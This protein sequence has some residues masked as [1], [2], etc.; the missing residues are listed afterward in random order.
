MKLFFHPDPTADYTLSEE[1]SLHAVK[2]LRLKE[3]DTL[4]I[5]DGKG[6]LFEAQITNAHPKKCSFAILNSKKETKNRTYNLHLAIAPTKSIDRMEWL[7]EKAVEVGI[8][9]ISFLQ[10]DRSERKNINLERVE[11][12][13]ISG[14]KQSMNL[15]LPIVNEMIPFHKFISTSRNEKCFIAHLEEGERKLF[16]K[17]ITDISN[18]L[19]LIGPE[20]DFSKEEIQLAINNKY[21]P[22]SLGT[23]RLRTETAA[24]AACFITNTI[25]NNL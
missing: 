6:S 14:M 22:V 16:Q 3:L 7:V 13:A 8:D 15:Y 21:T 23:S 2:V 12:I 25:K 5:I 17:E 9:E 18:I 1:E 4:T 20:G 11:K 24:L 19:L 10:C